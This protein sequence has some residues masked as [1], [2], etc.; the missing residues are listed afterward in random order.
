M[1]IPTSFTRPVLSAMN[2]PRGYRK[3]PANV[4]I[5]LVKPISAEDPPNNLIYNGKYGRGML[6]VNCQIH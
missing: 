4:A 2:P 1:A 6:T 5:E 3:R